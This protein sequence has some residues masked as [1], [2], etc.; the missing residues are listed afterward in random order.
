MLSQAEV[1]DRIKEFKKRIEDD[2][3]DF[4]F[5][6]YEDASIKLMAHKYLYYILSE[7]IIRDE[8]YDI[9]EKIWYVMGRALDILKEDEI[10]PCVDFDTNHVYA[11]QA[12]E[13]ALKWMKI[14]PNKPKKKKRKK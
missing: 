13:L 8:T 6:L 14:D 3:R 10:S 7:S 5:S 12:E 1:N 4:C 2:G 11:K 9:L